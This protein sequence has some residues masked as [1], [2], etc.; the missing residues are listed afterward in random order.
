V[1][2]AIARRRVIDEQRLLRVVTADPHVSV[3]LCLSAG[4]LI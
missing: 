2:P 4:L 1:D 3:P